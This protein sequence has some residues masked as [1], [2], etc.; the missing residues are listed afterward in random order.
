[1][2][3]RGNV[4]AAHPGFPPMPGLL[5]P[6]GDFWSAVRRE[7]GFAYDEGAVCHVYAGDFSVPPGS[8][9]P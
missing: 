4:A 9:A 7:R 5:I 6:C 3:A 8:T 2:L 1:M